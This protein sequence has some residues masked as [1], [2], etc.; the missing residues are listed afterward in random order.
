ME[1]GLPATCFQFNRQHVHGKARDIVFQL[2]NVLLPTY[3]LG[4]SYAPDPSVNLTRAR[5]A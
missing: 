1:L 5:G 3:L 4:Y 2:G